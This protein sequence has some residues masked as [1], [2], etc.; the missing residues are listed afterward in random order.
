MVSVLT[1]WFL[2]PGADPRREQFYFLKNK[3]TE[4][5][6][7][8]TC[9]SVDWNPHFPSPFSRHSAT[10]QSPFNQLK[11]EISSCVMY[12]K[13]HLPWWQRC[14]WYPLSDP[15]LQVPFAKWHWSGPEQ[16]PQVFLQFCPY[17][18]TSHS[19]KGIQN[20]KTMYQ[21]NVLL[22]GNLTLCVTTQTLSTVNN[23]NHFCTKFLK[24]CLYHDARKY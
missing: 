7:K 14:P 6:L 13:R 16:N 5:S 17:V 10:I 15:F 24:I 18:P 20:K 3:L 9:H 23:F 12:Y 8:Y 2:H 11:G 21:V 4:R 1:L 19:M 22:F